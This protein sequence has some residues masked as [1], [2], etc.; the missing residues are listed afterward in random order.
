MCFEFCFYFEFLKSLITSFFL[1]VTGVRQ[2]LR[3]LFNGSYWYFVR[4]NVDRLITF[5]KESTRHRFVL[6]NDF[7]K[8][9]TFPWFGEKILEFGLLKFL[10]GL[11]CWQ[12]PR[13]RFLFF[14]VNCGC[15]VSLLMVL[16]VELVIGV[17]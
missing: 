3:F 1:Y 12:R 17:A 13:V 15:F 7:R 2:K 4:E 9:L 6:S 10:L 8:R 5:P 14:G 16:T 11:C